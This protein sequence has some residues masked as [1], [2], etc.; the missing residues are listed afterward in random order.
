MRAWVNDF[1][2]NDPAGAVLV[3]DAIEGLTLADLR[4]STGLNMGTNGG[5]HTLPKYGTRN[6]GIPITIASNDAN[7]VTTARMNLMAA[8]LANNGDVTLRLIK[9]TGEAYLI[10]CYV[11]SADIPYG[12]NPL[13]SRF[14]LELVADDPVIYDDTSGAINTAPLTK[15]TSG[16]FVYPFT[17]PKIYAPGNRGVT[18]TN[19]GSITVYP[20]ITLTGSGNT[21]VIVNNT[22]G[23]AMTLNVITSAADT[24][25]IENRPDGRS[26]LLNGSNKYDKRS[27]SWIS[28][29]PGDNALELTT[30]TSDDSISGTVS[31]RGGFM[32]I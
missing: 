14:S 13:Y 2:I 8:L 32:S 4:R 20:T 17:Y 7:Q 15:S 28:L 12:P 10:Y 25:K 18:V 22:T 3:H 5:W 1:P 19:N 21:P 11:R 16:G 24:I 27:G 30:S 23:E 29:A 31:W 26:V 6:I 9:T